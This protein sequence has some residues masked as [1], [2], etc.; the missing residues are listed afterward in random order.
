MFLTGV[1][2][3]DHG[4][5]AFNRGVSRFAQLEK[6]SLILGPPKERGFGIAAEQ[7]GEV[8]GHV[9]A[10]RVTEPAIQT[11]K[12][13]EAEWIVIWKMH[14]T[15]AALGVGRKPI[16]KSPRTG[17]DMDCEWNIEAQFFKGVK[18]GH[19]FNHSAISRQRVGSIVRESEA[20]YSVL[21]R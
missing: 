9:E 17:M 18:Y 8:A 6:H 11:Q 2:I 3:I 10:N 1:E 19:V 20:E 14:N 21:S 12:V 13:R 15:E 4:N 5:N 16:Q 7:N